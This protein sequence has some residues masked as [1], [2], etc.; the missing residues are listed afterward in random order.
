MLFTPLL[1]GCLF[2]SE[3]LIFAKADDGFKHL[4]VMNV[5][6]LKYSITIFERLL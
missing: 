1:N 6:H 3:F 4:P 2:G 5:I